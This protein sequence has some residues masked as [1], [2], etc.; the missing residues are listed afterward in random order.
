MLRRK[1]LNKFR[2][3]RAKKQRDILDKTVQKEL[4]LKQREK[5]KHLK[6]I[7]EREKERFWRKYAEEMHT[8]QH[9]SSPRSFAGIASKK[10]SVLE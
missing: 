7:E 1:R 3:E 10:K 2:R 4:R 6:E 8:T 9:I 5:Q